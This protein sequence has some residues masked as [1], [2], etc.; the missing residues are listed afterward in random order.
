M[1]PSKSEHSHLSYPSLEIR[2]LEARCSDVIEREQICLVLS[3]IILLPLSLVVRGLGPTLL[4]LAF[5]T[6]GAF[7]V[8]PV[9]MD[10]TSLMAF[11]AEATSLR[12]LFRYGATPAVVSRTCLR[13]FGY[14]L[15]SIRF[16]LRTR[17][18][19]LRFVEDGC[20]IFAFRLIAIDCLLD[21]W[22]QFSRLVGRFA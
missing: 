9:C 16:G 14:G 20:V 15:Q 21:C 6:P 10:G 18:L 2:S 22:F 7:G 13:H 5:L 19:R 1:K 17:K 11:F 3:V 4:V 12:H 8:V